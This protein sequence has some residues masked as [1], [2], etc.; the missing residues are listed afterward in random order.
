MTNLYI[1]IIV[2]L[3]V[4]VPKMTCAE[5]EQARSLNCLNGPLVQNVE[6]TQHAGIHFAQNDPKKTSD[7]VTADDLSKAE[8][9]TTQSETITKDK[10][11]PKNTKQMK[12]F[13]PSETI[14]A[15]QG[16]DFPYDI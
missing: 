14:P 1:I 6:S 15:D 9:K 10:N 11:A 7:T 8:E 12:P 16:V 4:C 3:G 5:T 2:C 13:V